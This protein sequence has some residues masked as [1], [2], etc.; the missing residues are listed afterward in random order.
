VLIELTLPL[1]L[2]DIAHRILFLTDGFRID[3]R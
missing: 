1:K 3:M 2:R